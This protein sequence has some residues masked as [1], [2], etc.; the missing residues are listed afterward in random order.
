M[1]TC[2]VC[3]RSL[4]SPRWFQGKPYGSVHFREVAGEA[5]RRGR[6]AAGFGRIG[7]RGE[8]PLRRGELPAEVDPRQMELELTP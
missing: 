8:L 4:T 2:T 7:R 6:R 3:G 1:T 5:L